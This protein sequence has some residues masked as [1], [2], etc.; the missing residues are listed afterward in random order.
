MSKSP[1]KFSWLKMPRY[2]GVPFRTRDD[3]KNN[4]QR[5]VGDAVLCGPNLESTDSGVRL[6]CHGIEKPWHAYTRN[7]TSGH[8]FER[9]ADRAEAIAA[10]ER[11]Y[12][13]EKLARDRFA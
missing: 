12:L 8:W 1:A 3:D 7:S 13:S 2:I 11:H 5:H 9:F 10:V 6:L 4:G